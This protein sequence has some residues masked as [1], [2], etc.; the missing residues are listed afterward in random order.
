MAEKTAVLLALGTGKS[1]QLHERTFVRHQDTYCRAMY[2]KTQKASLGALN[3]IV[4]HATQAINSETHDT[5]A[6]RT[7]TYTWIRR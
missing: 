7:Q 5:R 1:G 2:R 4:L 3:G 6:T